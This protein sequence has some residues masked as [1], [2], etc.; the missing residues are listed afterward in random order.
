MSKIR[1][2]RNCK[3]LEEKNFQVDDIETYLS[4]LTPVKEFNPTQYIKQGLDIEVKVTLDQ[5]YLDKQWTNM[6]NYCSIEMDNGGQDN[7]YYYFI[8]EMQWIS[9]DA[10]KLVLHQDV[11]NTY[12]DAVQL[13]DKTTIQRMHK[14]RFQQVSPV[15]VSSRSYLD[16]QGVWEWSYRE[17]GLEGIATFEF[18]ELVGAETVNWTFDF[19]MPTRPTFTYDWSPRTG[20]LKVYVIAPGSVIPQERLEIYG[21]S[22]PKK[23][24]IVDE[25]SEGFETVLWGKEKEV[26]T[27]KLPFAQPNLSYVDGDFGTDTWYLSYKTETGY[28]SSD[29]DKFT[30][31]NPVRAYLTT[32]KRDYGYITHSGVSITKQELN[33]VRSQFNSTFLTIS[34]P[35]NA[36]GRIMKNSFT[37]N[38]SDVNNRS[39]ISIPYTVYNNDDVIYEGSVDIEPLNDRRARGKILMYTDE[40]S[41]AWLYDLQLDRANMSFKFNR[42]MPNFTRIEF[43][44]VDQ[45]I[46]FAGEGSSATLN[47]YDAQVNKYKGE[48]AFSTSIS[49]VFD[50]FVPFGDIDRS[51]QKLIKI[52]NVPYCPVD[53]KNNDLYFNNTDKQLTLS[54][55]NV[56]PESGPIYKGKF[57]PAFNNNITLNINME[58][59][60]TN[61]YTPLSPMELNFVPNVQAARNDRYE[62]KLY[63]SDFY[64]CKLV[65]DSFDYIF[66][67]E[68][69]DTDNVSDYSNLENM[70]AEYSVSNSVASAFG[71]NFETYFPLKKQ[72]QNYN[73]MIVNRNNEMTIYNNNYLNYLRNGYNYDIKNKQTRQIASGI[74][75]GL[76]IATTVAGIA[77]AATGY[78][79]GLG[80]GMI[81]SGIATTAGSLTSAISNSA[82]AD[83]AMQQK[84][85]QSQNQAASVQ[86]SDDIG[87]LKWYADNNLCKLMKFELSD[88][89]KERIADLFYYCGYRCDYQ[90][91]PN[92]TSRYWFNY[93]QCD[94]VY[95]ETNLTAKMGKECKAELTNKYQQGITVLHKRNNSY[96]FAQTKENW[97]TWL[98]A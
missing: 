62:S 8:R 74:G 12:K 31:N 80:A 50:T 67:L 41:A 30:L 49:R 10:I 24:R 73:V 78:G 58:E 45:V 77:L 93:I 7:T 33:S 21:T 13:T 76:G 72:F 68:L 46:V 1:L 2:Y 11:I 9:K 54:I 97:E 20:R 86:G 85:E 98:I 17:Y 51:D 84:L 94:P 75:T 48:R 37:L 96:D 64:Q 34:L 6:Y 42:M 26:L 44:D 79:S 81:V 57:D 38:Y 39:S 43:H 91:V 36:N 92:T 3:I 14:D 63:H 27:Q 60:S 40:D 56:G 25:V 71:F 55:Q 16:E 18:N 89:T 88:A 52:I 83:R 5:T 65:Y 90:A 87:L 29:P 61:A 35:V 22:V 82:Q 59:G 32:D 4:T 23:R 19:D 95:E 47:I 53:I 15:T 66:R 69:L 70:N 28:N